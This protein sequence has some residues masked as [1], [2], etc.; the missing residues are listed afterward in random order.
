MSLHS[1][2]LAKRNNNKLAALKKVFVLHM[3]SIQISIQYLFE[4]QKVVNIAEGFY[5]NSYCNA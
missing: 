3:F 2:F 1:K 4:Y 5:Q